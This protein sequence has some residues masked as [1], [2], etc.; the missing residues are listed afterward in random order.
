MLGSG[1]AGYTIARALDPRKYQTV[2]V[3]PRS[4]FAFTPLLASTAVG[5]LEFRTALEPIRTKRTNISYFQGWADSVDF[6]NKK[7]TIEEAV[8]D[9]SAS[10][11]LVEARHAG[12]TKAE[13][14]KRQAD[15]VEKGTRFHLTYDK[16]AISVGCYSQTFGTPG[17]KEH[18]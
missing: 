5:T 7:I 15:E 6:K 3:S 12:E 2:V 9:R 13:R 17:V 8:E 10:L 4:Y 16:L 18:A 11:A 14:H 1:W